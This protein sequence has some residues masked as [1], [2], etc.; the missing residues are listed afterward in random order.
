MKTIKDYAF[1][2]GSAPNYTDP[3]II[4]LRFNSTNQEMYTNMAKIFESYDDL[5]LGKEYSYEYSGQNLGGV[6]LLN[7]QNKVIIIVDKSNTAF[8]ENNRFLEYVNMTSG[9]IFMRL[10]EYYNVKNSPD[11]NEL[12]EYNRR[13]MTMVIPD[14]GTNPA[15]SSG[16]LCREAGCQMVAMRYQ[17]V[18][19]FLSENNAF[20]NE[21]T[22]AFVLKPE[23]LRYIPVTIPN[24]TPQNPEYS[25]ATRNVTT[26]YYSFNF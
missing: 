8:L 11:I 13:N 7:F 22:Y 26:D 16:L 15:N 23:R 2:S 12:Q 19:K 9:S 14:N 1:A 6:P 4:H 10:Y 18:D 20:F 21:G 25:Y 24:P 3:V 17:Y 5:V